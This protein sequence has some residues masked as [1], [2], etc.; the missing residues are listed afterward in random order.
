[1]PTRYLYHGSGAF[2]ILDILLYGLQIG[3]GR[4]GVSLTTSRSRARWWAGLKGREVH[5]LRLSAPPD[6]LLTPEDASPA[7][8]R[9]DF[10]YAHDISPALLQIYA[11][12]HW[13]SL[14]ERFG[15]LLSEEEAEAWQER[16][17]GVVPTL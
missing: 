15:F 9:F 13:E 5:L 10:T 16:W 4:N 2:D 6:A 12:G 17:S 7:D 8:P 1:M 11:D 3:E 14:F